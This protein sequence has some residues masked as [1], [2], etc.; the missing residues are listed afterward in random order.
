MTTHLLSIGCLFAIIVHAPWSPGPISPLF[1]DGACSRGA[2]KGENRSE[3]WHGGNSVVNTLCKTCGGDVTLMSNRHCRFNFRLGSLR[4][5]YYPWELWC[6]VVGHSPGEWEHLYPEVTPPYLLS[7]TC[8]RCG[9]AGS[10]FD[11]KIWKDHIWG[12]K[13]KGE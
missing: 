9:R 1:P 12:K 5:L 11:A 2:A 10:R 4:Q 8:K 13:E 7:S 6:L 3:Q